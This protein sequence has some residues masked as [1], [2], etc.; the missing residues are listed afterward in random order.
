MGCM[1][2]II[3]WHANVSLGSLA[4]ACTVAVK[5]LARSSEKERMNGVVRRFWLKYIKRLISQ[6]K[7]A[8]EK[9]W[10][11]EEVEKL[12]GARA[13][14]RFTLWNKTQFRTRFRT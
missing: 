14:T 6:E 9:T 5:L 13:S 2:E 12:W 4:E 11:A 8:V 7:R 1:R 3:P 10:V